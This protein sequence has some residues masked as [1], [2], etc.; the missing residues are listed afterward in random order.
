MRRM[1]IFASED[2]GNADPNALA[3]ATAAHRAYEFVGMPE[4]VLPMT[5][6]ALYLARAPKSNEALTAY[7]AAR[8][9]VREHGALP[10]PKKLRN[11]PTALTKK[12]GYGDGYKYPHNFDGNYVAGETYLPDELVAL[13]QRGDD[14]EDE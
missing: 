3:V 2:I 7:A 10:V 1:V 5:Q 12:M 14:G 8:R 11:A 4:G 9:L 6:A 13:K